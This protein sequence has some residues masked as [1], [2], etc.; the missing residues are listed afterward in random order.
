MGHSYTMADHSMMASMLS[1]STLPF[2]MTSGWDQGSTTLGWSQDSS[3]WGTSSGWGQRE[4]SPSPCPPPGGLV[5]E[6]RM[7]QLLLDIAAKES[8]VES[9]HN[10]VNAAHT[11]LN[12]ALAEEGVVEEEL[13]ELRETRKQL[14]DLMIIAHTCLRPP[15]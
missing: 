5:I 6:Q 4:R 8:E 1:S 10:N 9:T 12:V 11:A 15:P 13:K 3:G 14:V 7:A 2:S